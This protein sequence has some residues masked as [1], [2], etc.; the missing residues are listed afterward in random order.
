M[1]S[2]LY[3]SKAAS[4]GMQADSPLDWDLSEWQGA[5][6]IRPSG[7]LDVGTYGVLRDALLKCAADQ[8][9]AVIVDLEALVITKDQLTSVFVAVWLRISQWST[10]ALVVVPGSAHAALARYGPMRRFVTVRPTVLDA[11]AGLGDPPPRRRTELWLP[12]SPRSVAAAAPFVTDTCGNWDIDSLGEPAVRVA[13]ELVANAAEHARSPARL[14]LELRLGRLTVAVA[15]DDVRPVSLPQVGKRSPEPR[16]GLPLVAHLAHAAG[17][18]PRQSGGKIVW[19]VL[20]PPHAQ[21]VPV[22]DGD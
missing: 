21:P 9:R 14:R 17:W 7:V 5:T 11:L 6:I 19:A 15:D 12:S 13:G 4:Y 3:Q 16:S 18:S 2:G 10:V 8:P 1:R 20:R 22:L